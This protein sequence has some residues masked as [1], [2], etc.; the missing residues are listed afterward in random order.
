MSRVTKAIEKHY[1]GEQEPL[2]DVIAQELQRAGKNLSQLTVEDLGTIDEFHIG[3]RGATLK[4]AGHLDLTPSS[5]VLDIGSGLGGPART[6]SQHYGCK[7]TG[8]DLTKAFCDA[9]TQMSEWVKLTDK[10]K[11]MLGNAT[12]LPFDDHTFDAVLTMHT[13]MNIKEK[14]KL[15]HEA[16]RVL[17]RDGRFALYDVLQGTGG[18]VIYP[19]PWAHDTSISYLATPEQMRQL[20]EEAGFNILETIDSS[21]ES[22]EWFTQL[23]QRMAVHVGP[24]PTTFKIFLGQDFALMAQNQVRNLKE[25]RIS[26]VSFIAE[27]R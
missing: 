9:A 4:L 14:D 25:G 10:V 23:S 12:Q 24:P 1:Y 21:K 6:L 3:G 7:V 17:K 19:V 13:A 20:I 16:H 26:T 5:S 11:F 15:L 27:P 8:I 2:A 22:L 18:E